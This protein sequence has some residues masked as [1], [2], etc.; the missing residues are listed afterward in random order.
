[1]KLLTWAFGCAAICITAPSIFAGTIAVTTSTENVAVDTGTWTLGWSFSVNS[2]VSVTSLGAF[3]AGGDG[4]NVAHDVGIWD[5]TGNLLASATVPSGG[6]GFFDS[7]YR[8]VSISP[9]ALNAGS[10]Y[11]VG[12][13]YFSDDNDAWLYDPVTLVAAP[14]ITYLSRRYESS[15][16]S[17]VFPDL[18]GSGTTGYFGANFE[19]GGSSAVPEPS[20][21]GLLAVGLGIIFAAR[22]RAGI[23]RV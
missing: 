16:G 6:A 4:L 3:D 18:A 2:S 13:V 12:A 7:G 15:S 11:Y 9:L 19:F 17:L 1:M 14:Q 10:T 8:F 22:K 5:S 23:R 20:T 21:I